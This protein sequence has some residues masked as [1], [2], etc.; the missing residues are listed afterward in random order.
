MHS[1]IWAAL[2]DWRNDGVAPTINGMRSLE[3]EVKFL[4]K[5]RQNMGI[6]G[7]QGD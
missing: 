5:D 2:G 6:S 4:D 3:G 1:T 7:F